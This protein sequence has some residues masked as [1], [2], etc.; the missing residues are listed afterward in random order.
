MTPHQARSH[1]EGLH[2]TQIAL[3]LDRTRNVLARLSRPETSAPSLHVAGTNGKGSVCA[4]AER[5]LRSA[6]LRTGFYSSPH[7]LAF[8]ERIRIDGVPISDDTLARAVSAVRDAGAGLDLTYFEFATAM[9]F[10]AFRDA[11]VDV[12]VLETGLGGRLDATNVVEPV[13]AAITALGMDH[14]RILGST[15]AEI[16]FEKAGILKPGLTCAVAKPLPEAAAVLSAR[17]L[18]VG[19]TLWTEGRDFALEENRYRGPTLTLDDVQVGLRGPHQRQNAALALALLEIAAPRL[20]APVPPAALRTGIKDARWPGR[21]EIVTP[22]AASPGVEV[23]L[24]GAHNPPAAEALERAIRALWPGRAV[25]M[26]FGVLDDKELGPMLRTLLPLA[27]QVLLTTPS[28]PRARPA[29]SYLAEAR[30]IRR[31]TEA[32]PDPREAIHRAVA[33]APPGELVLICGSLYLVA[34]GLRLLDEGLKL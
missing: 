20:A 12:M 29:E 4:M 26:V 19:A 24:D 7:L 9:A 31:E 27:R 33:E 23:I 17:A 15:L 6:G 1:L 22:P 5:A 14:T 11:A 18:A 30:A 8:E 25:T 28:S 34:E 13:A 10:W 3:G 32:I 2:P 16:A 21:L